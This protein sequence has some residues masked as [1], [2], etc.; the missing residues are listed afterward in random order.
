MCPLWAA[1]ANKKVWGA[2]DEE[3]NDTDLKMSAGVAFLIVYSHC[4]AHRCAEQSCWRLL[5]YLLT[6][7]I[8][9]TISYNWEEIEKAKNVSWLFCW[10]DGSSLL[11][12]SLNLGSPHH[13]F[14]ELWGSLS[15]WR[16][17]RSGHHNLQ[18]PQQQDPQNCSKTLDSAVFSCYIC[19]IDGEDET[20]KGNSHQS[21][22]IGWLMVVISCLGTA[23]MPHWFF[24]LHPCR[25][26]L[27]YGWR[28]GFNSLNLEL[29][30][31]V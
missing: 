18:S 25:S 3:Q 7:V 14:V 2:S 27:A 6:I 24:K 19:S 20:G 15:F 17:Y 21:V 5:A 13:S 9:Y 16:D 22:W 11:G 28:R 4:S 8:P 12:N 23:C 31:K 1:T 26:R 10:K 29:T 30:N